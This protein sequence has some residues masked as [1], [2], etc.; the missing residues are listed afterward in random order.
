M[1]S[2]TNPYF[3]YFQLQLPH[4]S[5]FKTFRDGSI[6]VNYAKNSAYREVK[7]ASRFGESRWI[8][9]SSALF[10]F[11]VDRRADECLKYS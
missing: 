3:A 4:N 6:V 2:L 5:E 9:Y 10:M 1:T 8:L 7:K 11:V